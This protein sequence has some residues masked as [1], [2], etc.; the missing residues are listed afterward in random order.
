LSN[1]KEIN[2]NS[3]SVCAVIPFY[4]ER[5][6]LQIVLNETSKYV[7]FIMAVNDGSDD[8]TYVN[9]DKESK[10]KFIN[11]DR[12]YGKGKALSVG[13]EEAISAGFENVVTLD[14]DLQ[15]EPKYIP[16]LIKGLLLA[17]G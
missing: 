10:I 2:N 17:T 15:H 8:E 11:L 16:N 9:L 4:N 6:T 13:F 7:Q 14:A 3:N 12:N 1:S 5:E